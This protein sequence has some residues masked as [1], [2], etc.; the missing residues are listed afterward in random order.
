MIIINVAVVN[1]DALLIVDWKLLCNQL[2]ILDFLVLFEV[3]VFVAHYF[4]HAFSF[5]RPAVVL[6]APVHRLILAEGLVSWFSWPMRLQLLVF[7]VVLKLRFI[8]Q[9]LHF[10]FHCF[11]MHDRVFSRVEVGNI[12]NA[13]LDMTF[14]ASFGNDN[15]G[16]FNQ[17]H[18][19]RS[20]PVLANAVSTCFAVVPSFEVACLSDSMVVHCWHI[21]ILQVKRL[22]AGFFF[23]FD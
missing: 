4:V 21:L 22:C 8:P 17:I 12:F 11:N 13:H 7:R 20:R 3:H 6:A 18:S 15:P 14:F 19:L 1:Q 10:S 5:G 16:F 23:L 9:L 2:S